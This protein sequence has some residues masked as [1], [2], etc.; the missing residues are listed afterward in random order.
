[1]AHVLDTRIAPKLDH[2]T[3][4]PKLSGGKGIYWQIKEYPG[5][6]RHGKDGAK[7][8]QQDWET[9]ITIFEDRIYGRFFNQISLIEKQLSSGFAVMALDCLLCETLEQFYE[10]RDKSEPYGKTFI[11]FLTTS[12]F[13]EFFGTDNNKDTSI[14]GVFYDQIRC[15]ILH[16]A[17]AKKTSLIIFDYRTPLVDWSDGDHSGVIVNRRKFHQQLALEFNAY[18]N[19]LKSSPAKHD[20]DPWESFKKKMDYICKI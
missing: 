19:R 4:R 6:G 8:D 15:G 7:W 20:K 14:A 13:V 16:Q 12:S 9:A 1:M 5:Y 3:R 17:E 11:N 10:G 18:L 2:T